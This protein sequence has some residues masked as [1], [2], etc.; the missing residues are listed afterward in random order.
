MPP[1]AIGRS[2]QLLRQRRSR[3][4]DKGQYEEADGR[5][6]ALDRQA[7][8]QQE[9]QV[10]PRRYKGRQPAWQLIFDRSLLRK[11]GADDRAFSFNMVSHTILDFAKPP[12]P[13]IPWPQ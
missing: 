8:L 13:W 3:R 11:P 6:P 2:T 5:R 9:R 10:Q 7:G 4:D 1:E 12:Y